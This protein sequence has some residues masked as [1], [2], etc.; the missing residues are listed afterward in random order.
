[1][2][3]MKH[4]WHVVVAAMC[5]SFV[6]AE[7][8]AAAGLTL[9][10]TIGLGA[11]SPLARDDSTGG[12]G[13]FTGD[14]M[15]GGD[16]NMEIRAG[17]PSTNRNRLGIIRFDLSGISGDMS[18]A[19][20]RVWS[21]GNNTRDVTVYGLL[22]GDAG[23]SWSEAE[24]TYNTAPAISLGDTIGDGTGAPLTVFDG[25]RTVNLGT[26]SAPANLNNYASF[27]SAALDAFL[28]ADTNDL[29]SFYLYRDGG[30]TVSFQTK[31]NTAGNPPLLHFP[32]IP[33]PT[34]LALA[35]LGLAAVGLWQRRRQ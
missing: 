18:G 35:M 28:A 31:E 27:S 9:P 16:A 30:G 2:N 22:D 34:S 23:E 32:N 21:T 17:D 7:N 19:E 3:V 15:R 14:E 4:C 24:I 6:A 26:F 1:M 5:M 33:E 20:L 12:G 13:P 11:D 25:A 29:V 10:N 8:V